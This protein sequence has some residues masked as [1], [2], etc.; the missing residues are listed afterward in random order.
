MKKKN[1]PNNIT[2][3]RIAASPVVAALLWSGNFTLGIPLYIATA[4]TDLVD[5]KLARK[6]NVQSVEGKYL[7]MVADKIFAG[8][9]LIALIPSYPLLLACLGME[10]AIGGVSCYS[11][12]KQHNTSSAMIGKIKTG[13]LS[14]MIGGMF[15]SYYIPLLKVLMPLLITTTLASQVA[16]LHH[17]VQ[18]YRKEEK[19]LKNHT[20]T[21][22]EPTEQQITDLMKQSDLSIHFVNAKAVRKLYH[23]H[24]YK[25]Y[26]SNFSNKQS[27]EEMPVENM[28]KGKTLTKKFKNKRI[29]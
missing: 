17:Y 25:D 2:L 20:I 19:R 23:Y 7:D 11:S 26:M 5:G 24:L 18:S 21:L 9:M 12:K 16:T 13:I 8:I 6:W 22:E 1:I 29:D 4:L 27:L 10:M 15:L 28:T 14:V 3:A